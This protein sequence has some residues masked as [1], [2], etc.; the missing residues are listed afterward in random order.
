L[1][2][3]DTAGNV[4]MTRGYLDTVG[5][6]TTVTV[7]GLAADA[8]GYDV[9]VYADGD[10]GSATRT[11]AYQISGAGITTSS[12][13][14]TDAANTDFGGTFTQGNNSNGDYV[15]FTITANGFTILATPG[16]ASDGFPRAPVNGIQI[17]PK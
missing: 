9:Y 7:T 12:V 10:N 5:G 17:V 4:R 1:P 15:K 3:T 13:N 14:L 2:I 16:A 11:G 6:T 8:L